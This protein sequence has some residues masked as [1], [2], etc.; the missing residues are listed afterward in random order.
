MCRNFATSF[1]F[2]RNYRGEKMTALAFVRQ[3]GRLS[4]LVYFVIL[5]YQQFILAKMYFCQQHTIPVA[6]R[7]VQGNFF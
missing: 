2:L 6:P 3:P 4:L 5:S 1:L 7:E